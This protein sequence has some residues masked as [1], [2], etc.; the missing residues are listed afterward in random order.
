MIEPRQPE[1]SH[2]S[3]ALAASTGDEPA[4]SHPH[5]ARS[6]I[7]A[8]VSASV[9]RQWNRQ[10]VMVFADFN[11]FENPRNSRS[12][13]EE[14]G[15]NFFAKWDPNTKDDE[16]YILEKSLPEPPYHVF[17]RSKKKQIVYIVSLAGIF[18]PFSSNIIFLAL[19]QIAKDLKVSLSLII[20]TITVYTVVQG[21]SPSF[22]GPLSD[23]KGRRITFICTFL[24][25]SAANIGLAFSNN[26]TSLMVFRGIQA[27]GCSATTSVGAGVIGDI[28]TS[29]ERGSLIGIFGGMGMLGL[30]LGPVFGGIIS[31]YLGFRAIFWLLFSIGA[32][33]LLLLVVVLPE[34]LRSIAG[35][36]TIKLGGINRPLIYIFKPPVEAIYTKE[37]GPTKKVTLRSVLAPL[38]FLLEKDVFI[39]LFYGSIV[40]MVWSM[41][42][43]STTPLFQE[44]FGLND[45]QVG[46]VFLPNG[47]GCVVGSY[48][49]GYLMDSDYKAVER[50]YLLS[51]GLPLSTTLNEKELADFPIE[52]SR[53]RNM[54]W[55]VLIFVVTVA[56]YGYSLNLR[57]LFVPLILQF[58]ISYTATAIYSLN[59]AL[60]IDLHPAAFAS[61]TAVNGLIRYSM[62]A[63]GVAVV[64]IVTDSIGAGSAFL[65]FAGITAGLSPLI[66]MEWEKGQS[67]R[68]ERRMRMERKEEER[69]L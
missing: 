3:A 12:A 40:F 4:T 37:H 34:T 59:S 50:E 19:G 30:S 13:G 63:A 55:H 8:Q 15:T 65:F 21:L 22:W 23:T 41:V 7:T 33:V 56:A 68:N 48:L 6:S 20:L 26:F 39:T 64:L 14:P 54:W 1:A 66:W 10:S 46:L 28:T 61:I 62:S 58:C 9:A 53:M 32:F 25:Y 5:R 24:V 44:P 31:Q 42:A 18:S 51:K 35:N 49:T 52:R 2:L 69:V 27:A 43:A 60:L 29:K 17:T 57:T 16:G 38:K 47:A 67:W 11:I 45:L 36:G